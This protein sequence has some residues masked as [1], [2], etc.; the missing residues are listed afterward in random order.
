MTNPRSLAHLAAMLVLLAPAV[1]PNSA[2][3]SALRYLGIAYITIDLVLK[4]REGYLRRR[5]HWTRES[6]RGYLKLCLIPAGALLIMVSM[7]TAIELRLPIVGAARS[8]LRML[9]VLGTV[10]FLLVFAAGLLMVIERLTDGE[11]SRPFEW[12]KWLGGKAST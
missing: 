9:W 8:T 5:P 11:P 1:F 12:P 6:W 3:A 7:M 2:V 4:A 10:V